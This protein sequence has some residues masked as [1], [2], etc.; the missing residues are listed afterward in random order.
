MRTHLPPNKQ[1]G[2]I[3]SPLYFTKSLGYYLNYQ[4]Y[5]SKTIRATYSSNNDTYTSNYLLF[6]SDSKI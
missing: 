2:D 5:K 6:L 4:Y 3:L 1:K